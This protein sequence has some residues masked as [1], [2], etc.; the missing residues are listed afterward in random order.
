M[1]MDP[2]MHSKNISEALNK[3]SLAT[4]DVYQ[5]YAMRMKPTSKVHFQLPNTGQC[6]RI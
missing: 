4:N 2:K 5:T 3:N 6:K 1:A